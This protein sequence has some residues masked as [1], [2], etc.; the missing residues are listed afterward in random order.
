MSPCYSDF[1][2]PQLEHS[3]QV[4]GPQLRRD[5]ELLEQ[6]QRRATRLIRELKYLS[7]ETG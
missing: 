4:W 7:Y 2:R 5:V 3:I 1:V 6:V